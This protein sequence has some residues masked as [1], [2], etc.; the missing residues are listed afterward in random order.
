MST[1][2]AYFQGRKELFKGL[3]IDGL[4]KEWAVHPVFHLDLNTQKYDAPEKLDRVLNEYLESWER[5]YG[6]E[7]PKWTFPVV[8]AA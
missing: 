8:S 7:P 1:L 3:A 2:E 6:R 5:I 4:E